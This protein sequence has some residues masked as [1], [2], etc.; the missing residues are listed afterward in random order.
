MA[1]IIRVEQLRK[2]YRVGTERVVALNNIDL[3]IERGEVCC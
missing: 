1:P 2:V 3:A